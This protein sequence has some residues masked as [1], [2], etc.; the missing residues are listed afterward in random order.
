MDCSPLG[1][2]VYGILQARILEWVAIPFSRGS[3]RPRNWT[4]V[5][6]IA[7]RFCTIWA[8]REDDD[9]RSCCS[10][11]QLCPTLCSSMDCS[12]PGFSGP[13]CLPKFTQVHVHCIGDVIQPSHPLMPSSPSALNLSQHHG[14]FQ[15][16]NCLHQM[17]KILEFQLQIKGEMT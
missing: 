1:S 12:M 3:F 17:T 16:V 14:L 2:S 4:R 5:S 13:H 7:G 9:K 10:V 8:T 15:W 11:A 6:H